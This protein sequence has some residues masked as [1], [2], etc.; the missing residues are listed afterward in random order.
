MSS[1]KASE[2]LWAK[3]TNIESRA[4]SVPQ[5]PFE[6][7]ALHVIL[8]QLAPHFYTQDQL[9]QLQ[10]LHQQQVKDEEL[11]NNKVNDE[12]IVAK[13]PSPPPSPPPQLPD[14]FMN[15]IKELNGTDIKFLMKKEL[16]ETDLNPNQNRLSMQESKIGSEF[17]T[18]EEKEIT[19]TE[20]EGR[21]LVGMEVTVVDPRLREF[22]LSLRKWDT[23]KKED[24]KKKKKKREMM[25]NKLQ[26]SSDD[27]NKVEHCCSYNLVTNWNIV[28][29]NNNFEKGHILHVWSFRVDAK[30][31]IL[32]D[33]P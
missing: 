24:M 15:R 20:R 31:Y 29:D 11:E 12:T 32:L 9:T 19:L 13:P 5:K 26:Q 1:K 6:P 8:S 4:Q 33:K 17:L 22:T 25:K 14:K 28:V 27:G 2:D 23:K 18:E 3:I 7:S 30:L 10:N 21:Q 16:F